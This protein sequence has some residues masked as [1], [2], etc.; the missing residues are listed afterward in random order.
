MQCA[1]AVPLYTSCDPGPEDMQDAG[2][3][4]DNMSS[5]AEQD[6]NEVLHLNAR[7]YKQHCTEDV[8]HT[9]G[10]KIPE[11]SAADPITAKCRRSTRTCEGSQ[12]DAKPHKAG[13]RFMSRWAVVAG[14]NAEEGVR[15]VQGDR[16]LLSDGEE[17]EEVLDGAQAVD[18]TKNIAQ[19]PG[20]LH[21][22]NEDKKSQKGKSGTKEGG[23]DPSHHTPQCSW[24]WEE[25]RAVLRGSEGEGA[26]G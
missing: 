5:D 2:S 14:D 19:R 18:Q 13:H 9:G 11:S 6:Y 26:A 10:E 17:L 7:F 4:Y 21:Q 3:E 22:P 24:S 16:S 1:C 20:G 12:S 15:E 8:K 25:G 23:R